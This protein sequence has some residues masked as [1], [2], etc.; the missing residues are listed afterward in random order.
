MSATEL[1]VWGVFVHL[2]V[3]WL[4]QNRWI[5]DNKTR[6]RHPAGY[7]HAGLHGV[8]MLLVF[9]PVAAVALGV[10]HLLI[11]SRRPLSW[12]ARIVSQ[13]VEGPIAATVHVMRDQTLH[14]ATIG[15]AA[16]LVG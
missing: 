11:D 10:A 2:I 15:A 9:P 3:D 8:A 7:L 1:L 12:W 6:L 14:V 5:A 16:L 4:L 13:S